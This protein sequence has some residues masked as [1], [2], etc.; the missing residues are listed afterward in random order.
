MLTKKNWLL[1]LSYT[2]VLFVRVYIQPC[3]KTSSFGHSQ[4]E[5]IYSKLE[6]YFLTK[7]DTNSNIKQ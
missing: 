6:K 7:N 1:F 2:E 3:L 4:Q 5:M